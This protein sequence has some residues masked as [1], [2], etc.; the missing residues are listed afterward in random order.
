MVYIQVKDCWCYNQQNQPLNNAENLVLYVAFTLAFTIW[1]VFAEHAVSG[2]TN[3]FLY[4]L[5]WW[6]YR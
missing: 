1:Q 5:L 3:Y 6:A 4:S 2:L